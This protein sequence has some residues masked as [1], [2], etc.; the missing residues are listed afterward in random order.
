MVRQSERR[1]IDWAVI[2]PGQPTPQG[3]A[4]QSPESSRLALL[5]AELLATASPASL[6]RALR[7]AVEFAREVIELERCAIYLLEEESQLMVG[8]YGTDARGNTV[9]EHALS[10]QF[11]QVDRETFARAAAGLPWTVYEDCPQI[12]ESEGQTHVI[13]RGWVASTAIC[14]PRGPLGILFNDTAITH[15]PIDDAKQ[16]RAAI[17]CSVLGHALEPCRD[18]LPLVVAENAPDPQRRIVS[19]VTE[20]LIRDPTLSCEAIARE[21]QLSARQLTRTFQREAR[22]SLVE[23]RNELRLAGFLERIAAD[24]SDVLQA[25]RGAGFGSYAQFHRV[26]RARFGRGPREYLND[27]RPARSA[28]VAFA[29]AK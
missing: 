7:H 20:L 28:A 14:G 8:T 26:F 13:G 19:A 9:D 11:G 4:R 23:H 27:L 17:L 10:Y 22:K 25:A 29:P 3:P 1:R 5:T 24:A 2:V 15:A 21:L 12:A 18:A 6:D 16:S